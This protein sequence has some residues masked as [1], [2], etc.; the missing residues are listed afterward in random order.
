MDLSSDYSC[1][2]YSAGPEWGMAF[3]LIKEIQN[4]GETRESWIE[5]ERWQEGNGASGG[6][7]GTAGR[8]GRL[9]PPLPGRA[10][11][12]PCRLAPGRRHSARRRPSL[13]A[14]WVP[15]AS[16]RSEEKR[17]P[18]SS[19]L[20]SVRA[21]LLLPRPP[22]GQL[23]TPRS[24][25]PATGNQRSSKQ[26]PRWV[27]AR[28]MA[29]AACAR[30]HCTSSPSCVS[31]ARWSG[32]SA[33]ASF[34]PIGPAREE[35]AQVRGSSCVSRDKGH[36]RGN[37]P[38]WRLS[39][40]PLRL[41]CLVCRQHLLGHCSRAALGLSHLL[42]WHPRDSVPWLIPLVTAEPLSLEGKICA[43]PQRTCF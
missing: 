1:N 19:I 32:T 34:P 43:W 35:V 4:L 5:K 22:W 28:R 13:P 20:P 23:A 24:Q 37:L 27:S 15:R 7:V 9:C 33:P 14:D 17:R 8:P 21:A 36:L 2:I 10:C 26:K 25:P 6:C 41:A 31:R 16:E 12:W 40:R 11:D 3:F 42:L 29:W 30:R 38:S 39:H 18:G